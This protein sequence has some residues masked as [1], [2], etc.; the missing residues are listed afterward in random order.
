MKQHGT[1]VADGTIVRLY[2]DVRTIHNRMANYESTEVLDWLRRMQDEVQAY[3]GR[4]ASMCESAID[5]G[6]FGQL[7]DKLRGQN[8]ELLRSEPLA[9]PGRDLPLAWALVAAKP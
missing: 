9:V 1:E 8:F 3:A 7:C 4:M 6:A 5:A 2:K